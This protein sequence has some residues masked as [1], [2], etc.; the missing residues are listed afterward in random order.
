MWSSEIVPLHVLGLKSFEIISVG[1]QLL[2]AGEHAVSALL[3]AGSLSSGTHLPRSLQHEGSDAISS[4]VG[5]A[6]LPDDDELNVAA[7][8]SFDEDDEEDEDEDE[9]AAGDFV[10]G[11]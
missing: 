4:A 10:S 9:E 5:S 2:P 1:M 11:S 3:S 8:A 7:G 6:L